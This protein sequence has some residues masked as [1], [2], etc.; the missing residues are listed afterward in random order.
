MDQ[1][2]LAQFIEELTCPVCLTNYKVFDMLLD[3][4]FCNVSQEVM[5]DCG[6]SLCS[7]CRDLLFSKE[8]TETITCPVCRKPSHISATKVDYTLKGL[9]SPMASLTL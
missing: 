9:S 1:R 8:K 4:T 7:Q 5:L 2:Q 3:L 6:H